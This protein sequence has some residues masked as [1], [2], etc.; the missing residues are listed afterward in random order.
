MKIMKKQ[1]TRRA[2]TMVEMLVALAVLGVLLGVIFVPIRSAFESFNIGNAKVDTQ[3]AMQNSL[4]DMERDFRRAVYVFPNRKLE[5][6]TTESGVPKA[7]FS[8]GFPLPYTKSVPTAP[9]TPID[10][11][12]N[13]VADN[14]TPIKGVCEVGATDG[15]ITWSNAAR[16]DMVLART[17][18][19]GVVLPTE[20]GATIVSYYPRRVNISAVYDPIDNPLVLFRAEIP[21]RNAANTTLIDSNGV[22]ATPAPTPG[23]GAEIRFNALTSS[24]R[25]PTSACTNIANQNGSSLW[26]SHNVY[27]EA[28][29]E[30]IS[31]GNAALASLNNSHTIAIPRGL[32]LV[33]SSALKVFD[34]INT[35]SYDGTNFVP[36][37]AIAGEPPIGEPPIQAPLV[38]D[39]SFD[40]S[41]S[42]GDGKIDRVNISLAIGTLDA[43]NAANIRN[44]KIKGQQSRVTRA[45]NLI[46][47]R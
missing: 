3:T 33:S 26:L 34:P 30:G 17:D 11:S 12:T 5:K 36:P 32:Y 7:P 43:S 6:V 18:N 35:Y 27:G 44:G 8:A 13:A 10:V 2:F 14:G 29:L 15:T 31:S 45:V 47:V 46:N 20:A 28:N 41:D 16:V 25:Y 40:L 38:P 4:D 21:F 22:D 1:L 42:N 24:L 39:S 37:A 9:A 19:N 23:T